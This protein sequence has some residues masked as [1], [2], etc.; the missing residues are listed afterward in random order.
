LKV[1]ERAK[2]IDPHHKPTADNKAIY[3]NSKKQNPRL[4]YV[5]FLA[6][7]SLETIGLTTTTTLRNLFWAAAQLKN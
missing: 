7:I 3:K 1:A 2:K 6:E 4:F 5:C